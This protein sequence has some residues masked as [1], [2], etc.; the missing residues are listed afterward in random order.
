MQAEGFATGFHVKLK[1]NDVDP[2][3]FDDITIAIAGGE[4]RRTVLRRV[5][6]GGVAAALAAIGITAFDA[7]DAEAKSCKKK[8]DKKKNKKARKRCKKQCNKGPKPD[9]QTNDDC[10]A[11]KCETCDG[12][13]CKSTCGDNETCVGGK[14]VAPP[15]CDS[16][17]DCGNCEICQEGTCVST[18]ANNE[19]CIGD[20]A[21]ASCCA[22][23]KICGGPQPEVMICCAGNQECQGDIPNQQCVEVPTRVRVTRSEMNGW[24]G[25]DDE[26]DEQD[27][28]LLNFVEGPG[29]P[30][31]GTG[32]VEITV[33]GTQRR[34]IATYQFKETP[35]ATITAL[36]F[37]TFNPS[38]G[39][40]GSANR[41]GYLHFNVDFD[42]SDKWQK[43]LVFLPQDNGAIEQ[44]KWQPW[45]AIAGGD[46]KWRYSG[47]QWPDSGESGETTKTW[48]EILSQYPGVRVRA[49]DAFLGVRVGEPYNDGYT[50][51][52]SSFTFGTAAGTTIYDF[53]P[54]AAGRSRRSNAKGRRRRRR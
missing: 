44:D 45:D 10:D 21:T 19:T 49:T 11:G 40:G 24:F 20:G 18:C 17:D 50:E 1:G 4:T 51:N 22:S 47:S 3:Q 16:N 54:E 37:T 52:I 27:D 33:M 6:G 42:G 8:C 28:S 2:N 31:H 46:A 32:S 25:Y 13:T 26:T 14:C 39:N 38:E 48:S 53:E 34:N 41:S 9:C 23:D 15:E 5:F 36:E 43:R 12:G 29:S 7:D 30:I 35:L